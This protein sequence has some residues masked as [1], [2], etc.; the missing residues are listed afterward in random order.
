MSHEEVDEAFDALIAAADSPMWVVT[1]IADGRRAGCLVGFAGQV[2]ITPRRFLVA[3]SKNNHTYRIARRAGYL[4]VHLLTVES[5]DLARLFGTTT[6]ETADKFA[7]CAWSSGP[8]GL[9][10]LDGAVGWFA[11]RLIARSD[12]GDHVGHLLEPVTATAPPPAAAAP[13]LRLQ[14]VADLSPGHEA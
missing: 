2:S 4:G 13:A 3:V 1:T 6:G 10:I 5:L 7:Q 9:P 14:A 11:G 12:F 8:H